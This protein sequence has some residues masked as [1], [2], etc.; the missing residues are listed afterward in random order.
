M[1]GIECPDRYSNFGVLFFLYLGFFYRCIF[2]PKS[3]AV[4]GKLLIFAPLLRERVYAEIAQL[5][6]HNLA[7]VRVASSSLVFRSFYLRYGCSDGEIGRHEGLKIPWPLRL[8]GFK[9]H[10]EYRF[11]V[12]ALQ[13]TNLQGFSFF[14]RAYCRK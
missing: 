10:S 6:E 8:C 14:L 3:L 2:C 12:K 11:L 5:V 7:K 4:R 1:A 13:I 9:S